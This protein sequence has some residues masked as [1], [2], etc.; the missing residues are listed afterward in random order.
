MLENFTRLT[1]TDAVVIYAGVAFTVVTLLAYLLW[2]TMVG[3]WQR[4]KVD[5]LK[6]EDI[7]LITGRALILLFFMVW[8]IV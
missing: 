6:Q 3:A 4:Y 2:A 7:I 8:I 1:G 5:E